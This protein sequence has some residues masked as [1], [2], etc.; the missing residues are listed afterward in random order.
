MQIKGQGGWTRE[1]A[2]A[3]DEIELRLLSLPKD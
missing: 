1:R 3:L 2:K